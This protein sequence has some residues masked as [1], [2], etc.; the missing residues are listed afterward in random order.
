MA[1]HHPDLIFCR[2]Q[3]GVGELV[4]CSLLFEWDCMRN[5]GWEDSPLPGF[6]LGAPRFAPYGLCKRAPVCSI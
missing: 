2:K 4:P 1:K 5:G 3:A 6:G